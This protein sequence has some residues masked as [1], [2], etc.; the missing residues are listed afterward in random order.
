MAM[1]IMTMFGIVQRLTDVPHKEFQAIYR[2]SSN[3]W[4]REMGDIFI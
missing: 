2:I 1:C 3:I 4:M